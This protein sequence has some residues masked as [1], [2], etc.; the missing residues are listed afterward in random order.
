MSQEIMR[1]YKSSLAIF[2]ILNAG[3]KV[4]LI[5]VEKS[6]NSYKTTGFPSLEDFF[7]IL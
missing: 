7:Y 2:S 3:E 5:W 4:V 6:W 1:I